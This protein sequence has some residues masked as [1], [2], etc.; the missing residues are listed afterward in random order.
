MAPVNVNGYNTSRTSLNITWGYV[1]E[2]ARHG[3]ITKYSLKYYKDGEYPKVIIIPGRDS[4]HSQLAGLD[5]FTYYNIEL[6]A[7]TRAGQGV[8][9][10]PFRVQ[11][12][13]YVPHAPPTI[14][15][16]NN[17][18]DTSI[19]VRFED[20]ADEKLIYGIPIGSFVKYEQVDNPSFNGE[21]N[22]TTREA[23]LTG[24]K[25]YASYSIKVAIRTR[26]GYRNFSQPIYVMTDTGIPDA[27]PQYIRSS[28]V[29]STSLEFF[30]E[31]IL[32]EE[33]N[34]IIIAYNF[35][36]R[37]VNDTKKPWMFYTL[38]H[39]PTHTQTVVIEKLEKWRTYDY[40]VAGITSKGCGVFS[41]YSQE[42]TDEDIPEAPP[43]NLF[44][45][46]K[47]KDIINIT[48]DDVPEGFRRGVITLYTILY[49]ESSLEE[50]VW[51]ERRVRAPANEILIGRLKFYTN[52]TIKIAASTI[53]GI[54][55][56]S[57]EIMQATS[58]APP[59]VI[60][61]N[62]T[63]HNT[64]SSSLFCDWDR[65]K[66]GSGLTN[67]KVLGY[68]LYYSV[69]DCEIAELANCNSSLEGVII[70]NS[71]GLSANITGL[72]RFT[73]YSIQVQ[74]FNSVSNGWRSPP[75][76]VYT[77]ED[78]PTSPPLRLEGFSGTST[79]ILIFWDK[80]PWGEKHGI[81]QGYRA[82]YR[83]MNE[84][85]DAVTLREEAKK[86]R[87]SRKRRDLELCDE[88]DYDEDI[89]LDDDVSYSHHVERRALYDGFYLY[90]EEIMIVNGTYDSM[91][92][93]DLT[94]YQW[95]TIRL[96]SFT[97]QGEGPSSHI[98]MTCLQ[99]V[100][101]VGP[102]A[103]VF[104]RYAFDEIK[105]EWNELTY[106]ESRGT[107]FE[108]NVVYYAV[109]VNGEDVIPSDY[110]RQSI[111][112]D[113]PIH[114]LTVTNLQ[115]FT[116]YA[117]ELAALT[118]PGVGAYANPVYGETCRCEASYTTSYQVKPPVF[119]MN[120]HAD[121]PAGII[122]DVAAEA[123]AY[124]CDVCINGHGRLH[125]NWTVGGSGSDPRKKTTTEMKLAVQDGT[126]IILPIQLDS[127]RTIYEQNP[128]IPIV[129]SPGLA[130]FSLRADYVDLMEK[131][132]VETVGLLWTFVL[133]CGLLTVACG[134]IMWIV[135]CNPMQISRTNE[136]DFPED[137]R[138]GGGAGV[139]WSFGT[140]MRVG[141]GDLV[142]TGKLGRY[143]TFPIILIGLALP[144][145]LVSGISTIFLTFCLDKSEG[146]IYAQK[147]ATFADSYDGIYVRR[148]GGSLA[149]KSSTSEGLV[150]TL[151]D[152]DA[153]RIAIDALDASYQGSTLTKS[154]QVVFRG[155]RETS[156]S[157][158]VV[159]AGDAVKLEKCVRAYLKEH[160]E[161]VS[162]RTK[163]VLDGAQKI[164]APNAL[165]EKAKV[166]G[167]LD[168]QKWIMTLKVCGGIF[169]V[170]FLIGLI[171][172]CFRRRRNKV[173]AFAVVHTPCYRLYEV[174]SQE[175][176]KKFKVRCEHVIKVLE[177]KH[178]LQRER[179]RKHL[180]K[181]IKYL[182]PELA[183]K[184]YF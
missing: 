42:R 58:E 96:T 21:V 22:G 97:S 28:V 39:K 17:I 151:K 36:I 12:D 146:T 89:C 149:K 165:K 153:S 147:V 19:R 80:I 132:M 102:T 69:V 152:G 124:C 38:P 87:N 118:Y 162:R 83:R 7:F 49:T 140:V 16:G 123:V 65:V 62:F 26:H 54:G 178:A 48:W 8:Y 174:E 155:I 23:I 130:I 64:S 159:L 135:Q 11:T 171:Y 150:S 144:M 71:P 117:F 139:W 119:S 45:I 145:V 88:Y 35:T 13:E 2:A 136:E 131:M 112:V 172:E 98:N 57:E 84:G 173:S 134:L 160:R 137:F 77:E 148:W 74:L 167:T 179:L 25:E 141:Y 52:Y 106:N 104:D 127:S 103:T 24:L 14:V 82:Y 122:A 111:W 67:G 46:N 75:F 92:I 156:S 30:W 60:P 9:S 6:A 40:A 177:L 116:K 95:Y 129:F 27:P 79:S 15:T 169:G 120:N 37:K 182:K 108:Y 63:C 90:P 53:K 184:Y 55:N 175:M 29:S 20:I 41:T 33:K 72:E 81:I 157:Y 163:A 3:V 114:N 70:V 4:L 76:Y 51:R 128:Y 125:V 110:D 183:H 18:S 50:P 100:P 101:S 107:V 44:A 164:Y 43:D 133:V 56:F 93:T 85:P 126:N 105:I 32:E 78:L 109:S 168:S 180:R 47:T 99:S 66:E 94:E 161:G 31:D 59:V 143:C 176:L 115:P 86:K 91:D 1:P 142:A 68:N 181:T 61:G 73:N 170:F 10:P 166:F 113:Y 121:T 154:P 138:H 5:W 158:G 34:G